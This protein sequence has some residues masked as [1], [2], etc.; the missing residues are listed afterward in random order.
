MK[1]ETPKIEILLF[2]SQD[3]I[4]TSSEEEWEDDNAN[5][6]GWV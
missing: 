4:R 3:I 1:Y 5:S 2:H 6:D